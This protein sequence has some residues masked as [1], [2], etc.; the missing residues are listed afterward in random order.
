MDRNYYK[1]LC[2]IYS[3]SYSQS[4]KINYLDPKFFKD[5]TLSMTLLQT[6]VEDK[7][8]RRFTRTA[9]ARGLTPY[10]L[11]Q[12]LVE[13]SA[14]GNNELGKSWD[15]HW[16]WLDSLNLKPKTYNIVARDREESGE[17]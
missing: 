9:K 12:Q 17:R 10:S 8:A 4:K 11:L 16:Q 7:I 6:R 3:Q 14:A 2:A 1:K 13:K 15:D 5:Y